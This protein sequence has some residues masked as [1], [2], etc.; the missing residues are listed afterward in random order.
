MKSDLLNEKRYMEQKEFVLHAAEGDIKNVHKGLEEKRLCSV[1]GV[2]KEKV[3]TY[4]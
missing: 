2:H 4:R 1:K 3:R